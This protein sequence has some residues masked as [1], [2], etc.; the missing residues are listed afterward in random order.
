LR[1]WHNSL[2]HN[3]YMLR[4]HRWLGSPQLLR[5]GVDTLLRRNRRTPRHPAPHPLLHPFVSTRSWVFVE[6]EGDGGAAR[7]QAA[8]A[9]F[10][11][12]FKS[13]DVAPEPARQW[14]GR[15]RGEEGGGEAEGE[16]ARKAGVESLLRRRGLPN[17]HAVSVTG[18]QGGGEGGEEC[19]WVGDGVWVFGGVCEFVTA[20]CSSRNLLRFAS[21]PHRSLPPPS[22][23]REMCV[24]DGRKS[25]T[26]K[27][28][29]RSLL[30]IL[31]C[32]AAS[33][34]AQVRSIRRQARNIPRKH[35]IPRGELFVQNGWGNV[36]G[37]APANTFPFC[38][39]TLTYTERVADLVSRITA[40]QAPG[41]LVNGMNAVPSLGLPSYQVWSEGT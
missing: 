12:A 36:C 34:H 15:C 39:M 18:L 20:M 30:A 10:E 13:V 40:Q 17:R 29:M 25:F 38:N 8:D 19:G 23:W 31:A 37:S 4:R 14:R 11:A 3:C 7:A 5:K 35:P 28:K 33:V 41:V 1:L 16:P 24:S 26:P 27:E 9:M 2:R 22:M 21:A 32:V 6:G